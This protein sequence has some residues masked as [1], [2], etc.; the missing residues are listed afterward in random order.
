M[1]AY[2]IAQKARNNRITAWA[3]GELERLRT[4]GI[5][6]R[7]FVLDRTWADLRFVD[8]TLDP[9]DRPSPACYRGDPAAANRGVFGIGQLCTLRTWL[10]MWSLAESQCGGAEHL[11]R[12]D[13]PTLVVN[14]TED[15]GVFPSAAD[16]IAAAVTTTDLTRIDIRADHYFQRTGARAELTEVLDAWVT[17]RS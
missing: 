4:A 9:S 1:A 11:A 15:V 5:G 8:P 12:L 3:L 2:R 13:L 17:A 7:L 10:S 6:D 14:A 16:A